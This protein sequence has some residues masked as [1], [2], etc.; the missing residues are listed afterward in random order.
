MCAEEFV[1]GVGDFGRAVFGHEP[2]EAAGEIVI[3]EDFLNEIAV[4]HSPRRRRT[5]RAGR[6]QSGEQFGDG[7]GAGTGLARDGD[8][9]PWRF[10][11]WQ[12]RRAVI[13]G[14]K[15]SGD[16]RRTFFQTDLRAHSACNWVRPAAELPVG[17]VFLNGST[18][19]TSAAMKLRHVQF[20]EQN[21]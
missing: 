4:E 20:P 2:R 16:E 1:E 7:M 13:G 15:V 5:G 8:G 18:P 19:G 14:Q 21:A 11:L 17:S 6:E 3:F 12:G 10:R 9:E